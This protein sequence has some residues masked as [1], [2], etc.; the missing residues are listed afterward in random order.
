MD[1]CP[2][3]EFHW[4]FCVCGVLTDSDA[5][6]LDLSGIPMESVAEVEESLHLFNGLEKVI[7]CDCGIPSEE[8]DAL[9]KRHPETRFVWTVSV[10]KA[11]FRTDTTALIFFTYGYSGDDTKQGDDIRD[12]DCGEMK[13]L[14]DLV[15]L[16]IGHM[17][18][19]DLSFLEYMPNME[20][21]LLCDNGIRDI[22]PVGGLNKLKY[23]E[24]FNNPISDLSALAGCTALEDL[25]FT[26]NT[27]KDVTFL[28]E[29]PNL[30]NLWATGGLLTKDQVAW[31]EEE[32]ADINLVLY[33]GRSTA[34]GWRELPNYYKQ[35]DL[36]GMWYMTTP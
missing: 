27:P 33:S 2:D 21:L 20:Y 29:L 13:Y 3:A 32:F 9:W 23:L 19:R 25:N 18:I 11:R 8:M 16:D 24:T 7:M 36:L 14:V 15:C 4:Q 5:A 6:E 26:Y 34:A 35:R 22:T 12:K 28:K 17:S 10:A 31:M 30:K 1:L